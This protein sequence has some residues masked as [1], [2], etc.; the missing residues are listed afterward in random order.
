MSLAPNTLVL[1]QVLDSLFFIFASHQFQRKGIRIFVLPVSFLN[2]IGQNVSFETVLPGACED[3]DFVVTA[4]FYRN[5]WSLVMI[6]KNKKKIYYLDPL[7][8]YV[9]DVKKEKDIAVINSIIWYYLDNNNLSSN[10]P[11][12]IPNWVI[13]ETKDFEEINLEK[14]PKQNGGLDCGIFVV[15]YYLHII[16]MTKFDFAQ[17]DMIQIR[18]W[19]HHVLLDSSINSNYETWFSSKIGECVAFAGLENI[20][21]IQV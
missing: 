15:M 18:N 1:G 6:D 20:K 17:K 8:G 2:Q 14:I 21:Q 4:S 12:L 11:L 5:H 3:I 13:V 7:S 9:S 19:F 16:S 10:V